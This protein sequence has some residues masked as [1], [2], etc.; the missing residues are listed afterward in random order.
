MSRNEQ[1][2]I[3]IRAHPDKQRHSGREESM[4]RDENEMD[5]QPQGT[6]KNSWEGREEDDDK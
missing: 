3:S 6:L 5:I 2:Y 1:P 4:N